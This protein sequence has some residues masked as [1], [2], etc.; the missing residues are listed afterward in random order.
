VRI[1]SA[2]QEGIA[3]IG[4]SGNGKGLVKILASSNEKT[5]VAHISVEDAKELRRALGRIIREI[6]CE[7]VVPITIITEKK[8]RK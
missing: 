1:V 4:H 6:E 3:E 2:W 8:G 7:T 5:G